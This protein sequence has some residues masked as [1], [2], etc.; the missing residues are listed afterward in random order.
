MNASGQPI[1]KVGNTS[2]EEIKKY[3]KEQVI[4]Q[5]QAHDLDDPALL[6]KRD[7]AGNAY[8]PFIRETIEKLGS[9]II[10]LQEIK[11]KVKIIKLEI[12]LKNS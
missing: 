3:F 1:D 2:L 5:I 10:A 8:I 9:L 6:V 4:P 12:I 7:K 11:K